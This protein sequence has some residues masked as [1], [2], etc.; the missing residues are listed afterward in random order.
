MKCAAQRYVRADKFGRSTSNKRGVTADPTLHPAGSTRSS[1]VEAASPTGIVHGSTPDF[2]VIQG[3]MSGPKV[4]RQ[5]CAKRRS[6]RIRSLRRP[7]TRRRRQLVSLPSPPQTSGLASVIGCNH[8]ESSATLD[9][10]IGDRQPQELPSARTTHLPPKEIAAEQ[11]APH[12]GAAH[13]D[14]RRQE[15]QTH[16]EGEH[17][18]RA[19]Q[20]RHQ[21][22]QGL[23]SRHGASRRRV[24]AHANRCSLSPRS[25]GR[26][27]APDSAAWSEDRRLSRAMTRDVAFRTAQTVFAS[28]ASTSRWT[29]SRLVSFSNSCRA[30]V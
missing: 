27:R 10:R 23:Q 6:D 30:P 19:D 26:C 5:T 1:R 24:D 20:D 17:Q 11:E 4:G 21:R 7:G 12:C 18:R 14:Q 3:G 16:R 29:S 25:I 13:G 9:V 22:L 2:V 15:P 28:H 8:R